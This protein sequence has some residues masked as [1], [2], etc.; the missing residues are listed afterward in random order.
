MLAAPRQRPA[1]SGWCS[2]RPCAQGLVF[3][4]VTP[5]TWS[6]GGV[7]NRYFFSGYGVMLF[8]LPPIESIG[9]GVRAVG[10]RRP[11]RRTDG[12]EPVRGVVPAR[13]QRQTRT[14]AAAAGRVD[15][16]E[17]PAR[18]DTEPDRAP[19]CG[20]ATSG[21]G[22]PGF[23]VS[24]LDDNAFGREADKSFWI[25]GESRAEFVIKTDRPIRRAIFT[26]AAGPVPPT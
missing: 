6:G 22:D 21:E 8:L 23:L 11:V 12:A 16:A 24:F 1:G 3:L 17:R 5:Y 10:D 19:V 4:I 14:A 26:V 2:G 9:A 15:A 18:S 7:G 13:G 20:S 25:R